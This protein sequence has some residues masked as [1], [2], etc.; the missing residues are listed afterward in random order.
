MRVKEKGPRPDKVEQVN[1]LKEILESSSAAVLA[2]YR[3]LNVKNLS[4][5]RKRLRENEAGI[6][7]VKNTLLKL[8]AD[9]LPAAE[10]VEGLE[11]PTALA[12]TASDPVNIAK[13]LTGFAKEFRQ[14]VLKG[15]VTDGHVLGPEQIS[16]LAAVPPR[17]VLIGQLV[18]QLQSP[19]SSFVS[20]MQ[21]LY[22]GLV[23]T[24]QGVADKKQ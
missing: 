10:L 24:L 21:Q 18:G 4:T 9:G 11:G 19:V 17:Q 15:G 3:G 23:Y 14:L 16:A 2:D 20:T 12:Y 22:G 5:L 8:A 7:I 13:T 6:R 1:E